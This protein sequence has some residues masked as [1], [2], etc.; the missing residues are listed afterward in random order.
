MTVD[1]RAEK[2]REVLQT[3]KAGVADLE[4][5]R[6]MGQLWRV[7]WAG[8]VALLRA[9]GHVLHKVDSQRHPA[10][11]NA[12]AAAHDR[13]D[14]GSDPDDEIF[15]EFIEK[16]RNAIL[17]EFEM[18]AG[19]SVYVTIGTSPHRVEYPVRIQGFEHLNQ[20]E[21]VGAAL[22]WWYRQ[23][24]SIERIAAESASDS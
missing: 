10:L 14:K 5:R 7:Q 6:P 21:L 12:I 13:A 23:I 20:I 11:A 9:V 15:R 3:I 22:E 17:K 8:L 18:E 4:S 16:T 2:A 1:L 24:E 19:Q